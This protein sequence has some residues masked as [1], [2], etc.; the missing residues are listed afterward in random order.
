MLKIMN[1]KMVVDEE[2]N[3]VKALG[4]LCA[5]HKMLE[6]DYN[7]FEWTSQLDPVLEDTFDMLERAKAV[8]L[9]K[10]SAIATLITPYDVRKG[11]RFTEV[12]NWLKE[13]LEEE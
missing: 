5:L 1:V 11:E 10:P 2:G 9:V 4:A 13:M 6:K 12:Y 8:K 7:Y 3:E